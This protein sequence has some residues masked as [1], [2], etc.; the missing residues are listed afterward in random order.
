MSRSHVLGGCSNHDHIGIIS[1]EN[2]HEVI[3]NVENGPMFQAWDLSSSYQD[4]I[5][6]WLEESYLVGP[7]SKKKFL[8]FLIFSKP[9]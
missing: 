6:Q 9:K 2:P 1:C 5:A 4:R 8:Y 7:Y 3:T